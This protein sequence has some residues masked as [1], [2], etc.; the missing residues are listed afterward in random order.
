MK[1]RHV[2]LPTFLSGLL[3]AVAACPGATAA[4]GRASQTAASAVHGLRAATPLT[5]RAVPSS[6]SLTGHYLVVLRARA[7]GHGDPKAAARAAA[8]ALGRA[9]SHGVHITRQFLHALNGYAATLTTAQLS[10]VRA[11]PAVAY[12]AQEHTFSVADTEEP[13]PSWGI[14]RIDQRG[15]PLN[16]AYSAAETGAGVT[17]YVIDTGIR[18]TH[19][20]FVGR[21]GQGFSAVDDGNGTEDCYGHGTHVAGTIGGTTY[22]IAKQVTLVPVRVLNCGGWAT[23]SMVVAGVDWVTA[24]HS[25]PSVANMSL[26]GL[27][28]Q[29]IDDA[30]DRSV[31]SGVTYVVAAGNS[32]A[33]ACRYSPARDAQAITVGATTIQ[34]GRAYFSNYGNCIDVFAPGLNITSAWNT[35]DDASQVLSGTSMATPHVTGVVANYLQDHPTATPAEATAAV[36]DNATPDMVTDPGQDSPN[37]L[38]FQAG[39]PVTLSTGLEADQLRYDG[40]PKDDFVAP[41]LDL[42]NHSTQTVPL[43]EV[44][45]R[46]WYTRDADPN[47]IV[48]QVVTCDYTPRGCSTLRTSVADL[49]VG[50]S[51]ADS[52]VDVGFTADAGVLQPGQ[53]TGLIQLQVHKPDYSAYDENNDWSWGGTSALESAPKVTVYVAGQLVWGTEP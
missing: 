50:Q 5:P 21:V 40:D 36:L 42:A 3:L 1:M 9:R 25:G 29:T 2:V 4:S 13:T 14:D 10:A 46:Y 28:D 51:N 33:D 44:T 43:S 6:A 53:D 52:F 20:E 48:H 37:R 26:G 16:Y 15:L 18:S 49:Y 32:Q 30:V 47:S 27:A 17:A 19:H 34:D 45:V 41:V 7:A 11:D 31:A 8:P 22:G 23:T 38:L 24:N 12:V 35:A 39:P